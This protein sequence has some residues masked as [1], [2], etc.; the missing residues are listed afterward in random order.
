MQIFDSWKSWFFDLETVDL[1]V[2]ILTAGCYTFSAKYCIQNSF[3]KTDGSSDGIEDDS[4]ATDFGQ[5]VLYPLVVFS[6]RLD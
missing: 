5:Y 6:L 2:Q 1:I 4:N 3:M